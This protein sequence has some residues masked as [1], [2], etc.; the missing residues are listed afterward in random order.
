MADTK[1]TVDKE[2]LEVK[3]ERLM[4]ASPERLFEAH[5][6][7]EQIPKWWGPSSIATVVDKLDIQ[8][9]GAWRFVQT[10]PDGKVYGFSG[11]FKEIDEPHKLVS[12]FEYEPMPGHVLVQT[13]TF[14]EQSDG[15]TKVT[16]TAHYDNIDD[17]EGMV[18]MGMESGQR[19]SM[20]RLSKLVEI[21][22]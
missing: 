13:V 2:K 17:L 7:A 12:T 8:V 3:T 18:S 22:N 14:E 20:D 15:T 4:N 10:D 6:S 9:G 1:F 21:S 11:V 16:T 19:E 5:T